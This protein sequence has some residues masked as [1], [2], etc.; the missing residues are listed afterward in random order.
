LRYRLKTY[1]KYLIEGNWEAETDDNKPPIILLTYPRLADLVNA[2]RRTRKLL[3]DEYYDT[4]DIPKNL[5]LR[6]TTTDQLQQQGI[7]ASIWE[8]GRKRTAV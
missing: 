7:A 5:H 4:E 3:L 2:K 6:F 1:V 8:E